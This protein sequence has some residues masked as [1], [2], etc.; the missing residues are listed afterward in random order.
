MSLAE[1]ATPTMAGAPGH[2][3]SNTCK[4]SKASPLLGN[5]LSSFSAVVPSAAAQAGRSLYAH[6]LR[7]FKPLR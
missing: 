7:W 3:V 5:A 1:M 2:P 6:T 4:Q